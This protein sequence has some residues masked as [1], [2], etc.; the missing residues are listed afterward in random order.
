MWL[1][2]RCFG[3]NWRMQRLQLRWQRMRRHGVDDGLQWMWRKWLSRRSFYGFDS[4][5]WRAALYLFPHFEH[6]W[7]LLT[8]AHVLHSFPL[9]CFVSLQML[10]MVS[11]LTLP[12]HSLQQTVGNRSWRVWW[13]CWLLFLGYDCDFILRFIS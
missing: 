12:F 9:F 10:E 8:L 6:P 1:C 5:G 4:F 2:C 3:V 7:I 13:S 11:P